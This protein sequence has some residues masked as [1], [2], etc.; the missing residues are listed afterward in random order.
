MTFL[1]SKQ[2]DLI[3]RTLDTPTLE[4]D[5]GQPLTIGPLGVVIIDKDYKDKLYTL[6]LGLSVKGEGLV[7]WYYEGFPYY[8]Y[9]D[10]DL[11]LP[12]NVVSR[13][14]IKT[15][16]SDLYGLEGYLSEG[17]S[18]FLTGRRLGIE[19]RLLPLPSLEDYIVPV[20][21]YLSK[22]KEYAGSTE[23]NSA[24]YS[25]ANR[26]T[27]SKY[28]QVSVSDLISEEE[29]ESR[30]VEKN[31][32]FERGGDESKLNVPSSPTNLD[33]QDPIEEF[34]KFLVSIVNRRYSFTP[35]NLKHYNRDSRGSQDLMYTSVKKKV[36]YGQIKLGILLDVSGSIPY[37]IVCSA[38]STLN[39]LISQLD[40]QS[41]VVAWDEEFQGCW[42]LYSLPDSID[43]GGGTQLTEALSYI[44]DLNLKTIVVFSDFQLWDEIEFN[45]KVKSLYSKGFK[46]YG[47]PT[48]P[49]NMDRFDHRM[50]DMYKKVSRIKPRV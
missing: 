25:I 27:K 1:T 5:I 14:I 35:D 48:D 11:D 26:R 47:Y 29:E 34:K 43:A 16:L 44:E 30:K 9:T 2:F 40:R 42:D 28:K 36:R 23:F 4:G 37:D 13:E 15:Y 12:A 38:F 8:R 49:G 22:N 3:T 32:G 24:D 41:R 45:N 6:L 50:F 19:E 39:S 10:I 18:D 20:V 7:D 17:N 46:V 31:P 33:S 21:E